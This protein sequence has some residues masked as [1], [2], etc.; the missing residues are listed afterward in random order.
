MRIVG[1]V[2]EYNPLHR[3][4]AYQLQAAREAAKADYVLAVMSGCF[5]Q[6]GDAALLSPVTRAEMALCS[7]AD[8]VILLP[9]LWS[10]RDAEHFALGSVSLLAA[11]GADALSFGAENASAE[12][13]TTAAQVLETSSDALNRAV[14]VY[15]AQGLGYPSAMAKACEDLHPGVGS[16]LASPNNTLGICYLRALRRLGTS[17]EVFPIQRKGDYHASDFSEQMPSATAV[18][19]GILRGAWQ[20]AYAAMPEACASLLRQESLAGHIHR[21]D[22]L[23]HALM[24]RLRTMTAADYGALPGISEG[25]DDR[26]HRAARQCCTKVALLDEASTRR[27]PRARLNRLCAHALLGVTQQDVEETPLPTAALLLGFRRDA[28]PLL[29]RLAQG[30][31]PLVGRA[32]EYPAA[33]WLDIEAAA[34]DVWG[35]GCGMPAGGLYTRSVVKV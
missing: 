35:L 7:G 30:T 3:G 5:T 24:Y 26:L 29:S 6:R 25:I 16:M 8:A 14:N 15:L 23:D 22:A 12:A 32:S 18:R 9:A 28:A 19:S 4:H 13:L 11:L 33:R 21:P 2:A 20:R 31:V 10:V 34:W 1:V 27:Y 17:M